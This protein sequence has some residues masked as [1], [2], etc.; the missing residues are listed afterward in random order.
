MSVIRQIS[1]RHRGLQQ[2][3]SLSSAVR[4]SRPLR[5]L[6]SASRYGLFEGCSH[7]WGL[8]VAAPGEWV[9][10]DPLQISD[11]E[12]SAKLDW[13][14]FRARGHHLDLHLGFRDSSHSAAI[15]R[16]VIMVVP[17]APASVIAASYGRPLHSLAAVPF[18]SDPAIVVQRIIYRDSEPFMDVRCRCPSHLIGFALQ[19]N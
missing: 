8:A 6:L 12:D 14:R 3:S 16:R 17:K 1:K 2:S 19:D 7:V 13:I 4:I 15:G 11:V 9:T 5:D 18:F 10:V